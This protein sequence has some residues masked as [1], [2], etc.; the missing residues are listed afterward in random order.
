MSAP[1]TS[2][3]LLAVRGCRAVEPRERSCPSR[4]Q[5]MCW[6]CKTLGCWPSCPGDMHVLCPQ[7]LAEAWGCG[8]QESSQAQGC[9]S[10]LSC[11]PPH[12]LAPLPLG[13]VL[14]S[15]VYDLEPI[16]HTYVN[17]VLNMSW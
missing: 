4:L 13:A 3:S 8:C 17:D 1:G 5:P 12:P 2:P 10:G 7:L 16:L 15:G 6:Q 9:E 14:V 11:R